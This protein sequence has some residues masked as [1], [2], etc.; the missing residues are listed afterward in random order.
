MPFSP[1]IATWSASRKRP[2]VAISGLNGIYIENVG[3]CGLEAVFCCRNLRE[4]RHPAQ[5]P[6]G[7]ESVGSK[8]S[9]A[10]C[11]RIGIPPVFRLLSLLR[12]APCGSAASPPPQT[13]RAGSLSRLPALS[14]TGRS[15]RVPGNPPALVS[16]VDHGCV[17][18]RGRCRSTGNAAR[19]VAATPWASACRSRRWCGGTER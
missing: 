19:G 4:K 7:G 13:P 18:M 8:R 17:V 14:A 16:G 12:G 2:C 1:E 6:W 11:L 10:P 15:S 9:A 3:K 5:R